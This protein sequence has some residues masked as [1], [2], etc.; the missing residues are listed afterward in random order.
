MKTFEK[1]IS[2][3]TKNLGYTIVLLIAIALFA[4]FS[5]GLLSGLITAASALVAY[6]CVDLLYKEFNKASPKKNK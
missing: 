3:L 4:I 5:D 2:V 6:I 1:I